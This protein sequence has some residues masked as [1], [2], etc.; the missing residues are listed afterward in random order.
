[1][2][3]KISGARLG[4]WWESLS[5]ADRQ[6]AYDA[7]QIPLPT[8]EIRITL[9]VEN[10]QDAEEARDWAASLVEHIYHTFNDDGSIK[11]CTNMTTTTVAADRKVKR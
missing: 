8:R 3:Q 10:L 2:K 1:M 4:D 9:Q 5:Y 6:R 11:S 7:I